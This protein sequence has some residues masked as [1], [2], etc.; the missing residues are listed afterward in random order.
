[1][2]VSDCI[3]CSIIAGELPCYEIYR[4]E[5]L[6]CFL[7]IAPA[8]HGHCLIVPRDHHA[9]IFSLPDPLLTAVSRFAGRLAPLLKQ[10]CAAEGI[11][12]H[13][14]NGAA[15]GQTVFHYHMHLIPAYPGQSRRLHGREPGDAEALAQTAAALR[16]VLAGEAV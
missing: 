3:F 12:V 5:Q 8:S 1:M 9:D 2:Q 13:Q 10:H 4:D 16:A 15:A 6:L 11:G 7:D 14:L